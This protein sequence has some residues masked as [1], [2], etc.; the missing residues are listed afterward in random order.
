VHNRKLVLLLLLLSATLAFAQ[1]RPKP[2]TNAPSGDFYF[3]GAYSGSD[4]AANVSAGVG[5]G[6]DL[7]FYRWI[8]AQVDISAY[9]A[10]DSS[11]ANTTT[12]VD[13]LFGPHFQKPFSKS[14]RIRP[15]GDVL[16]GWQS[17][18]NSSS[19]HSYYYANGGGSALAGDGGADFRLTKHLAIRGQGGFVYSHYA[20]PPTTTSNTRWRAGS[21]L[22]YRF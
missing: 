17:F 12:T 3:G 9:L 18:N 19:Q 1:D 14:T 13:Y 21:Y 10:G 4:P 2:Q 15:F 16:V 8:G 20:T 7:T 11:V 6:L 22:V 5:G